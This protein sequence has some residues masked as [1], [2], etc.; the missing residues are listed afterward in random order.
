MLGFPSTT[1]SAELA[2]FAPSLRLAPQ[3][4]QFRAKPYCD[5]RSRHSG[6][7]CPSLLLAP[8]ARRLRAR[9]EKGTAHS[10]A[11]LAPFCAAGYFLG[12][13]PYSARGLSPR[14][15]CAGGLAA[16]QSSHSRCFAPLH[17]PAPQA[18]RFGTDAIALELNRAPAASSR[19]SQSPHSTRCSWPLDARGTWDVA[20][21]PGAHFVGRV[22]QD[23]THCATRRLGREMAMRSAAWRRADDVAAGRLQSSR[24]GASQTYQ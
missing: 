4:S 24:A 1:S 17:V 9:P 14:C 22:L 3:A 21:T 19:A 13:K 7:A 11:P 8:Q 16:A 15:G 6:T 18:S 23:V 12:A 2:L 5:R 20:R 10:L